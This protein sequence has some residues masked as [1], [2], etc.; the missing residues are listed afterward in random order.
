[1]TQNPEGER[2]LLE[3]SPDDAL[4]EMLG[5]SYDK[6]KDAEGKID[7][8]KLAKSYA[9][10]EKKLGSGDLAPDSPDGYGMPEKMPEGLDAEKLGL[11]ELYADLHKA[12][13]TKKVVDVVT[14]KYLD[15]VGR[16][17]EA[18]KGQEAS[19]VTSAEAELKASWGENFET[20]VRLAQKAFNR[21]A[22]PEDKA[23]IAKL[24][25]ET[26]VM[27][28]LAKL[29]KNMQEDSPVGSG[30]QAM[31][32][33]DLQSLMKSEAYWNA[34]HPDHAKVKKAVTDHFNSNSY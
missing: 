21:L 24:G 30:G 2:N 13:A 22:D 5:G 25:S 19:K 12:G 33:E 8:S 6:F 23:S 26:I 17:L 4:K 27:K 11:K 14:S 18:Q 7:V 1:M 34:K 20:N 32:Q 3:P 28:F 31:P 16:G 10:L 15:M 9:G 29:G